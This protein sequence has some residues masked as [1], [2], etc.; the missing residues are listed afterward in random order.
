MRE[1]TTV[2]IILIT[3]F[4]AS[5]LL[6]WSLIMALA[7]GKPADVA[8]RLETIAKRQEDIAEPLAPQLVRDEELSAVPLLHRLM[9][10][11]SWSKGLQKL[12]AQAG[13]KIKPGKFVLVSGVLAFGSLLVFSLLIAIPPV[14]LLAG[15]AA[16]IIPFLA[17]LLQRARRFARFEGVFPD[18]IDLLTRS[19]RAGHA[20]TT[21]LEMISRE[22]PE[23]VAG[24]FRTTFDEYNFG[25][26]LREALVHLTERMP[27]PDVRFFATA[28]LIQKESGGNLAELLESMSRIIR[29]RF[30]ILGEV[31]TRTAQGRLTAGILIALPPLLFVTLNFLNP[32]YAQLLLT[33]Q[34]GHKILMASFLLQAIGS[35]LLWK[36]VHIEV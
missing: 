24:E 22:L 32:G 9:A 20:F 35:A 33:E 6:S 30:K 34:L 12:L 11:W 17:V 8:G 26:P 15:L 21:G 14:A 23:P 19:V 1:D 2:L 28:M 13:W 29:E 3:T 7:T 16:G 18:A 31:R 5:L 36:I 27:L 25:L 4:L 10:R